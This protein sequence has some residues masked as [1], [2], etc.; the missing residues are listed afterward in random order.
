MIEERYTN[1]T[2]KALMDIC[3][4]EDTHKTGVRKM[5]VVDKIYESYKI[6]AKKQ[7]LTDFDYDTFNKTVTKIVNK[8]N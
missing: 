5:M 4:N 8:K 6:R 1:T 7:T 2:A 3:D